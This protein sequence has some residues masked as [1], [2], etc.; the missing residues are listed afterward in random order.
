MALI[1]DISPTYI[2]EDRIALAL[3]DVNTAVLAFVPFQVDVNYTAAMPEGLVLPLE[4]V[5]QAPSGEV[6]TR[7]IFERTRPSSLLLV[8][9]Q[10]GQH[11]VLL[12]EQFH[13]RWQGRLVVDVQGD[14][15]NDGQMRVL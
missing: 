1:D 7:K 13:N 6:V 15:L 14:D 4:L 9:R 11:F 2:G 3:A 5:F 12:R 10:R 8:A